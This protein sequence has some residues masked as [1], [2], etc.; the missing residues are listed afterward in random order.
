MPSSQA[1]TIGDDP[2]DYDFVWNFVP[3]EK[4]K[5]TEVTDCIRFTPLVLPPN[6]SIE[7]IPSSESII[8]APQPVKSTH[9]LT[10]C[11]R[12]F[13]AAY[14]CHFDPATSALSAVSL[15]SLNPELCRALY[16]KGTMHNEIEPP[17]STDDYTHFMFLPEKDENG[18]RYLRYWL[19]LERSGDSST[20][21][22]LLGKKRIAGKSRAKVPTE[23][24][25]RLGLW[26][27]SEEE[28]DTE[29]EEDEDDVDVDMAKDRGQ[30]GGREN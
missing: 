18:N 20:S 22:T 21:V 12:K 25:K 24:L 13:R 7:H 17:S 29:E 8:Q 19:S 10:V 14:S 26:D 1:S 3:G 5:V 4:P 6:P 23:E 30:K 28:P 11:W 27:Q 16:G 2:I 9:R 15:F